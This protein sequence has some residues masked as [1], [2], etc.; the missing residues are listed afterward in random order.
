[1]PKVTEKYQ[2]TIPKEVREKIGLKPEK[3]WK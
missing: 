1:M 3:K 2:V